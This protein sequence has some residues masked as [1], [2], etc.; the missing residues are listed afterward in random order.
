M[1]RAL[2]ERLPVMLCPR[3][4]RTL[5]QPIAIEDVVAYL[6]AALDLRRSEPDVEI[7]GADRT[8]YAGIMREYARQRG[9]RRLMVP[10]P[11]LTPYLSS[12]W[13]GLATPIYA[14]VGREL[15]EGMRNETVVRD[16]AALA[17]LRHPAD[18]DSAPALGARPG[19]RGPASRRPAGTTRSPPPAG[20]PPTAACA[21]ARGWSTRGRSRVPVPRPP[22]SRRSAASA[23]ATAGTTAT[24]CGGCAACSISS[25]AVS[26]SAAAAATP[27]T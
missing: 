12:L 20:R 18:A 13:L 27:S 1:I 7:G 5:T 22:R 23:A 24:C 10:V 17:H 11:V 15:V 14:R 8:S 25:S 16:A 6:R 2:V 4:V 26:D 9:L 19:A 21:S 3:W